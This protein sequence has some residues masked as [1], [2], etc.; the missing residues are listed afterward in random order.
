MNGNI[1]LLMASRREYNLRLVGA[2][3]LVEGSAPKRFSATTKAMERLK[4]P[5]EVIEYHKAHISIDTRHSKAWFDN[6]LTEYADR[7]EKVIREL[8]LGVAIRYRVAIE[9]Y[10]SMLRDMNDM[11]AEA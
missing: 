1:L 5:A 3:G 8:S 6:V 2:V 10:E 4:L 9:Y 11:M 7:G